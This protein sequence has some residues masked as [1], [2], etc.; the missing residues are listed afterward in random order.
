M[1]T[2][3]PTAPEA[4]APWAVPSR[5]SPVYNMDHQGYGSPYSVPYSGGFAHPRGG[6][7]GCR[8]GLRQRR[9]GRRGRGQPSHGNVDLGLQSDHPPSAA[10]VLPAAPGFSALR[11]PRA[12]ASLSTLS[13]GMAGVKSEDTAEDMDHKSTVYGTP[14]PIVRLPHPIFHLP[15]NIVGGDAGP[16]VPHHE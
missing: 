14:R 11:S 1:N 4:P 2:G 15:G 5:A 12:P 8:R 16:G 3:F 13:Q 6:H 7:R 9:R 10:A